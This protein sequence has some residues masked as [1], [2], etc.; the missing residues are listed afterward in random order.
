MA[1]KSSSSHTEPSGYL[2]DWQALIYEGFGADARDVH[3][4]A[5]YSC[6][7]TASRCHA[8]ACALAD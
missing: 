7:A 8:R 3:A 2:R 1:A 6:A 5:P 4:W